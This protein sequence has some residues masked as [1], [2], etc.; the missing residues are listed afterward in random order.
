MN[1]AKLPLSYFVDKL[2]A[3]EPVTFVRYGDGE[4]SCML[5]L[6]GHNCDGTPYTPDLGAALRKTVEQPKPYLYSI[7]PK[8]TAR[9]NWFAKK[10]ELYLAGHASA[11]AWHDS[12]VLLNASV[13]GELKPFVDA[14]RRREVMLV[15]PE[16]VG[17]CEALPWTAWVRV[18]LP[19][20][21]EAHARLK[22]EI[23]REAYRVDVIL[24]SAGMTS[25]VLIWELYDH[26]G[27]SKSL[28]DC[29]SLWDM[30]SGV[31]SRSYARKRTPDEKAYLAHVNIGSGEDGPY[32]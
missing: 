8:V 16:H 12:E 4:L 28:I 29:G 22:E 7:G 14:L 19:G 26:L 20:A 13:A 18:P 15:G 9:Q 27:G 2:R 21:W 25:K 10:A 5:G 17:T 3:C 30:Y 1:I 32:A 23:L 24:F 31:D 6:P 11:I